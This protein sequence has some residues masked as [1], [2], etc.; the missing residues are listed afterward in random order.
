[1]Y[2]YMNKL[3]LSFVRGPIK[4]YSRMFYIIRAPPSPQLPRIIESTLYKQMLT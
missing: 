1:M 3:V 2:V 4:Y